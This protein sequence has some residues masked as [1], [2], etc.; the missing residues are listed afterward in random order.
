MWKQDE[1]ARKIILGEDFDCL[2]EE[3][4]LICEKTEVRVTHENL[5][6]NLDTW[7]RSSQ[8]AI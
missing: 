8:F 6:W 5:F 2:V 3:V 1:T 4:A 7:L